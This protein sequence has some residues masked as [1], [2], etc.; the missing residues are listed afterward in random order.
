MS[1]ET[2]A[3]RFVRGTREFIEGLSPEW[4]ETEHTPEAIFQGKVIISQRAP[5]RRTPSRIRLFDFDN[6]YWGHLLELNG[7]TVP[8]DLEEKIAIKNPPI[9][10]GLHPTVKDKTRSPW[11]KA[12][13]EIMPI[14]HDI[15]P[16][17]TPYSLSHDVYIHMEAPYAEFDFQG[18]FIKI[19]I[20][21]EGEMVRPDGTVIPKDQIG[22]VSIL[23]KGGG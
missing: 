13:A 17:L 18:E 7:T 19:E 20:N 2:L 10:Y 11:I 9:V 16:P 23:R 1:K 12:R 5:L 14:T 15:S 8:P 21:K 3:G 22:K 4:M 6:V